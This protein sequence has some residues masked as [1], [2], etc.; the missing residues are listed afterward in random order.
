MGYSRAAA[1]TSTVGRHAVAE[2]PMDLAVAEARWA[3][4][5]CPSLIAADA[6]NGAVAAMTRL[7]KAAAHWRGSF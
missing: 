1:A 5:G 4:T 6:E 7:A 2:R 3:E